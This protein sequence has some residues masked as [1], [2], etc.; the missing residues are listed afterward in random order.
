M[1]YVFSY[2]SLIQIHRL[3]ITLHR[4]DRGLHRGTAGIEIVRAGSRREPYKQIK[5]FISE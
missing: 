1:T 4:I 3:C 5:V 2:E